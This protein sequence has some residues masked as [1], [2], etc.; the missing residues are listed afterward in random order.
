M[1][2]AA[3]SW[4]AGDHCVSR[5]L[6]MILASLAA[7]GTGPSLVDSTRLQRRLKTDTIAQLGKSSRLRECFRGAST[8]GSMFTLPPIFRDAKLKIQAEF[9]HG[10]GRASHYCSERTDSEIRRTL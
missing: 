5:S 1:G 6:D 9:V 4:T 7:Y 10:V 3:A 2:W 8:W